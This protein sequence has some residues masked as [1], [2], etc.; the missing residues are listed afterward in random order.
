MKKSSSSYYFVCCLCIF[1]ALS[2]FTAVSGLVL[3]SSP[4]HAETSSV[5]A[6]VT[7]PDVCTIAADNSSTAHTDT[8]GVGEYKANI[9]ET[10]FNITCNDNNGYSI[11]AVG[12]SNNTVGNTNLIGTTNGAT[13]PTGTSTVTGSNAVSNWAMKLTAVSGT[14]PATILDSYD[15]Y[16]V[17]PSTATKVATRTSSIDLSADSQIKTT[18]AVSISPA[19]TADSYV[20][21][22]KYTVVHPNYSNADG[23][24][25][26]YNVPVTFAGQGVSSVTFT[27]DGYPTRTVST[28]GGTANLAAGV[29]YTVTATF[30]NGYELASWSLNN[31]SYGTIG[32]TSVNPT[33]LIP[34]SNSSSAIITITGQKAIITI[35]SGGNMQDVSS[36]AEGGCPNTLTEGQAYIL[37]DARDNT[38]YKVARLADGNCWLLDNL[39]LDI[40]TLTMGQLYGT[41]I[42]AGKMT[43]ASEDTLTILK[44]G[45]G[46]SPYATTAAID[47]ASGF[48]SY[49]APQINT[50]SVNVVPSGAMPG[51]LGSNKVGIY[52]NYCAASAGSYC[53]PSSGSTG[54]S[55]QDICP[56]GWR[57]PASDS[58]GYMDL[59]SAYSNDGSSLKTALST[60]LSGRYYD[61]AVGDQGS[62]GNFWSST[63]A[64]NTMMSHLSSYINGI[65]PNANNRNYGYSVRCILN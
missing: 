4:S 1:A 11:Y 63:R 50:G 10:V 38:S 61:N 31:S 7:V 42:N 56:Y 32:S 39:A 27:A 3:S 16:H 36:K 21:K 19:Q 29:T 55:T 17:V 58:G 37:I 18:Y 13:I 24:R 52:Y 34:N 33:T 59:Y 14:F 41:G 60:P 5:L 62:S 45:G 25:E 51:S 23:T 48:N 47:V 57:M 22:V 40:A 12:Y 44:N 43:N 26:T 6:S 8:V 46:T 30:T 53:Y 9:G 2:A 54:N 64:N 15:S 65:T 35:A 28:G 20:G 49:I